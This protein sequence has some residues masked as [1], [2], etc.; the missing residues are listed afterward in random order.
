MTGVEKK[1]N[2][3]DLVAYKNYDNKQYALIPGVNG[4]KR[5]MTDLVKKD[6]ALTLDEAKQRMQIF[7]FTRE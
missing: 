1:M 7:G 5:I 6:K 3:E 2:R 4:Q